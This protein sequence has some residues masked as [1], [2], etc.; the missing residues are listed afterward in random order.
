MAM[1][2][3][4]LHTLIR[5]K[6]TFIERLQLAKA[7]GVTRAVSRLAME[8]ARMEERIAKERLALQQWE[9]AAVNLVSQAS[10]LVDAERF[11]DAI[12]IYA[13]VQK[14]TRKPRLQAWIQQ[15][16]DN[17]NLQMF[18]N[19]PKAEQSSKR[20]AAVSAIHRMGM[21][22]HLNH[23]RAEMVQR[24]YANE[25]SHS[26]RLEIQILQERADRLVDEVNPFPIQLLQ[27]EILALTE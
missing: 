23:R 16:I 2:T 19:G 27:K 20:K 8:A 11:F 14:L 3:K 4:A 26:E 6:N 12:R 24:K 1:T 18:Q 10:C 22:P 25:L 13:R 21:Q 9:E 15:E 17:L 7:R 5:K